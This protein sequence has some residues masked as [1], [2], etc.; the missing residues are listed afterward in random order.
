MTRRNHPPIATHPESSP[1]I[2]PRVIDLFS[3]GGHRPGTAAQQ[4][5][6]L[7]A[8]RLSDQH[9]RGAGMFSG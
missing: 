2:E 1:P 4:W 3:P 6:A 7:V 5:S 9:T 8:D